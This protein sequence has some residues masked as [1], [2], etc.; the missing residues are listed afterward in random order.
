MPF[1]DAIVRFEYSGFSIIGNT[2]NGRLVGLSPAGSRLCDDFNDNRIDLDGFSAADPMLFRE[3]V[4]GGFFANETTKAPEIKTLYLHVTHR[5]NLNCVGCYSYEDDRNRLPDPDYCDL[6]KALHEFSGRN[7]GKLVISGGEPFL[8]KDLAEIVNYA[9][10]EAGFEHVSILTNGLCV[11]NWQLEEIAEAVDEISVSFDGVS[12]D[13]TAYIRHHQHFDDLI[14]AIRRIQSFNIKTRIT[15]TLNDA[16]WNKILDYIQLAESTDSTI[17]FSLLSSP[18]CENVSD[19][20]PSRES[21]VGMAKSLLDAGYQP[22][23]LNAQHKV[24]LAICKSCGAGK[25]VISVGAD[26][27]VFPCHMLHR[28]EYG[29]GNLFHQ[30]LDDCLNGQIGQLF[31]GISVDSIEQCEACEYR[32]LCGGGC[33]ARSV[34]SR[35]IPDG[36]DPYCILMKNYYA[37]YGRMLRSTIDNK[38]R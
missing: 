28:K 16:N 34:Y 22:S 12:Q 29:M 17:G 2:V 30:S 38:G 19:L 5:C 6:E 14:D 15:P 9:K 23:S 36:A 35:K 1:C 37:E 21:L 18:K 25:S 11:D 13:D 20:L 31:R 24:N 3:M 4:D 27:T 8:R 33:R 7:V 32:Y 26:G 10:N